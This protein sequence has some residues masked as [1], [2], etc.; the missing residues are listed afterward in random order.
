MRISADIV[1]R[2]V[3]PDAQQ[4]DK[5]W[6]MAYNAALGEVSEAPHPLF[7]VC[8]EWPVN[9]VLREATGLQA[10]NERLVHAQHDMVIHRPPRAGETLQIAGRVVSVAQRRPGAFVVLRME[11]RGTDVLSTTDYGML[12]RGVTSEGGDRSLDK[13][14]DPPNHTQAL[15]EIGH[16]AVPATA[17]HVYTECA[18]IWNPI[19]TDRAY[20]RAAGLPDIILHGTATLAFSISQVLNFFRMNPGSVRRVRC[21]FA[22]MVLMPSTL[23]VHAAREGDAI[24][25][26][27]RNTEGEAVIQRGW[28]G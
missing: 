8:Y 5:R 3:G 9:R 20:A 14:E 16:V 22:G 27:T 7:P 17:A 23:T 25:F 19:H 26:E 28:I 13:V 18:R 15:K 12:Y 2:E 11:T 21:R 1:G 6:L 24:A 4:V 10:L